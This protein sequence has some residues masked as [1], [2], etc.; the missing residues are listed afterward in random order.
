MFVIMGM[1]ELVAQHDMVTRPLVVSFFDNATLLPGAAKLGV[2]GIPVHPGISIGTEF[3]YNDNPHNEW[4]QSA[5]LA[6]HYHRYVHHAIH[7]YS[8]LG[9]RRHFRGAFDVEARFG[10]GYLHAISAA[11][12]FELNSEGEYELKKSIGKPQGSVSFSL[13]VGYQLPAKW[14]RLFLAYQF[15]LHGPFVAEYVPVLPNTAL[16]IGIS[17]PLHFISNKKS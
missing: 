14:P 7:L 2:V 3:R 15:Y 16:H 9:Y 17:Y 4:F 6:Y 10:L 1:G 8:E 5:R 11:Q 13:G 12:Q